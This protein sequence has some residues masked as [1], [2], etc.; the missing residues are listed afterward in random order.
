[1]TEITGRLRSQHKPLGKIVG[2]M[3]SP[4]FGCRTNA[5]LCRV[6][7]VGE[8]PLPPRARCATRALLAQAA[9]AFRRR[10]AGD[11]VLLVVVIGNGTLVVPIDFAICQPAP[12]GPGAPCRD[13]LHWLQGMLDGRVAA[14]RR[15]GGLLPAPMVVADSWFSDSKLMRHLA[16]THEGTFLVAGQ[17]THAFALPDGR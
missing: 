13:K 9:P 16:T 10:H 11:G 5:E 8:E 4:L 2:V 7:G 6:R 12:S 15:R 3:C 14:F 17:S 1:V